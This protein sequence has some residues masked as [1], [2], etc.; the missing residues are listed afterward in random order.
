MGKFT[1]SWIK[2]W[3]ST[4]VIS[5]QSLH[6]SPGS[7]WLLLE[8]SCSTHQRLSLHTMLAKQ[9]KFRAD[10]VPGLFANNAL[11][12]TF[13]QHI[14][15]LTP[16]LS[17]LSTSRRF[18]CCTFVQVGQRLKPLSTL[19]DG[20]HVPVK[21]ERKDAGAGFQELLGTALQTLPRALL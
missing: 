3:L 9:R 17:A 12:G 4:G 11:T 21:Q 2:A 7:P 10:V 18:I 6:L 19:P 14:L 8:Q 1:K 15:P 20:P 5:P 13:P 16:V